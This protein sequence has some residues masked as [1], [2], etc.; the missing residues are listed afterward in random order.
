VEQGEEVPFEEKRREQ[1][2]H[3]QRIE[4]RLELGKNAESLKLE[5]DFGG[6]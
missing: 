4:A 1:E 5:L 6:I 3:W 2:A